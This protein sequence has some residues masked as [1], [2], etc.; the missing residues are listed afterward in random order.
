MADKLAEKMAY[1]MDV[2]EDDIDTDDLSDE[3]AAKAESED[4]EEEIEV[5][6]DSDEDSDKEDDDDMPSSE[7]EDEDDEDGS[8]SDGSDS[9]EEEGESEEEEG[10]SEEEEQ[11]VAGANP[12]K[13]RWRSGTVALREIRKLQKTT[14]LL[15]PKKP[16]ERVVRE[17]LQDLGIDSA[18]VTKDAFLALQTASEDML[19]ELFEM[20]QLAAIHRGCEEIT[21]K[22]MYFVKKTSSFQWGLP[23][24]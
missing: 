9:D 12:K 1:G 7:S 16:F 10:E 8:D 4:D 5:N 11:V 13:R 6:S 24:A 18:R 20:T 21:P 23:R 19:T 14:D 3:E 22:D 17:V 15:I 2:E